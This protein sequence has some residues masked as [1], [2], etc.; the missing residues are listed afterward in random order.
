MLYQLSL[1]SL[2]VAFSHATRQGE[3][4]QQVIQNHENEDGYGGVPQVIFCNTT[5]EP[6]VVDSYTIQPDDIEPGETVTITLYSH[7]IGETVTSGTIEVSAYDGKFPIYNGNLD[8]CTELATIG[9]NCPLAP[10]PYNIQESFK[11]PNLPI[12][13]TITA[14]THILDQNSKEIACVK[15]IV[16]I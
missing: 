11:I 12:S 15:V 14:T 2:I 5:L 7:L 6:L 16:T 1:L 3:R 13:G 10:G 9:I 8:L 4:L